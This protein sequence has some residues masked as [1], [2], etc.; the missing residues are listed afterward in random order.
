[1]N[2]FNLASNLL[3]KLGDGKLKNMASKKLIQERKLIYKALLPQKISVRIH[4]AEEGGFWAKIIEIPCSSQGETLSELFDMLTR[5]IYAYYD[6][7]EKFI[8]EFGSYIPVNSVRESVNE[9]KPEKYTLD[10]ILQNHPE[11][12]H[13]LQRIS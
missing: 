4:K 6:V 7:P 2:C 12:I 13:E 8:P 1:M 3:N 9:Q 11:N 5:A 10:D